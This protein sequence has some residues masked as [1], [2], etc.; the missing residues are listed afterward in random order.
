MNLKLMILNTI[1]NALTIYFKHICGLIITRRNSIILRNILSY[2]MKNETYPNWNQIQN[3]KENKY[4][5]IK[6]HFIDCEYLIR[7]SYNIL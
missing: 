4:K 5:R 3:F 7:G 6:E 1:L 2:A